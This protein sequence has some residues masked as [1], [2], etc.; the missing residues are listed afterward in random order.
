MF[1]RAQRNIA[2]VN[3]TFLQLV[4]DGMTRED[5]KRNIERRPE[6]WSRF[7]SWLD[8]LPSD[9]KPTSKQEKP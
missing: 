1:Y 5:L 6:L 9:S 2:E 8:K 7:E 4:K 3:E